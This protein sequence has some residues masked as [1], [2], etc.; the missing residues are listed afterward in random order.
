MVKG[1]DGT[2]C[3]QTPLRLVPKIGIIFLVLLIATGLG[4]MATLSASP[5]PP[6]APYLVK[7]INTA[8]EPSDPERLPMLTVHSSFPPMMASTAGSCGRATARR[9]AR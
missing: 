7:D 4:V 5:H 9:G 3:A 1:N 2:Q 6:G 8:T